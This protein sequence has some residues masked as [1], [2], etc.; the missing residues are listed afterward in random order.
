MIVLLALVAVCTGLFFVFHSQFYGGAV[1]E[2]GSVYISKRTDYQG[3]LDSLHPVLRHRMAFSKYAE[4][5]ELERTFKPG[6]YEL[7][8][9]QS[10][11]D[12]V[13]MLKLGLQTPVKVTFNIA[14]TPGQLAGKLSK[15][16]DAD[17]ME[18]VAAFRDS[19]KV[20]TRFIPN[21]YEVYWTIT[22]EDFVARMDKEW[23]RFWTPERDAK[24]KEKGLTRDEVATLA[25]IVIEE[26]IKADEMPRV[27]GVYLNRLRKGMLLQADPTVKYALQDFKLKRILRKHLKTESPYNTYLH[28]GLPPSPIA[29]PSIVALDAV[30]NAERHDYIYF[31]ARETFDGYHNFAVTYDEHLKNARRY[32][33]ELDR[34]KIK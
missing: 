33:A 24:R 18:F 31:C 20:F 2:E 1:R 25:S 27:A 22:P 11:V 15:Q 9:G 26:T 10:V 17:S 5:L 23:D 32:A 21:T 16:L 14:R 28:K 3:L 29:L 8:G 6:H 4:R 30:L 12:V 13:R 34:R 19:V 7:Q